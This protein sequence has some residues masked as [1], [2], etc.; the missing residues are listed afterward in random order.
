MNDKLFA[1]SS[2]DCS[3]TGLREDIVLH[4]EKLDFF[5]GKVYFLLGASGMG[6]STLL[7]TL[8]LMN[9]TI[10]GGDI[11][12]IDPKTSGTL[13]YSE[14]WKPENVG[15]LTKMRKENLSFIFQETNLMENFTAHENVSLSMMIKENVG[16]KAALKSALPLLSRVKLGEG[17][18][19]SGTLAANLSGGQRQR[20]AFVRALNVEAPVLLCDEPT[21]N[22]DEENANE[23]MHVIHDHVS[24]NRIAIIVSHDIDLAVKHADSII[25]LTRND[26]HGYG[27]ISDENIFEKSQWLGSDLNQLE[28]FKEKI[29]SLYRIQD[30]RNTLVNKA[31]ADSEMDTSGSVNYKQLFRSREGKA[32]AGKYSSNLFILTLIL[33]FTFLAIGFANGS[34]NYLEKQM[35]SVFVNWLNIPVSSNN[36]LDERASAENVRRELEN[37]TIKR[38]Y[39]FSNVSSYEERSL[40]LKVSGKDSIIMFKYRTVNPEIDKTLIQDNVLIDKNRL[41]GDATGITSKQNTSVIVTQD[42]L[43]TIHHQSID[44]FPFLEVSVKLFVP[45]AGDT[46]ANP[47]KTIDVMVKIPIIAVVKELPAGCKM[48]MSGELSRENWKSDFDCELNPDLYKT[49]IHFVYITKDTSQANFDRI[50]GKVKQAI[51]KLKSGTAP[52]IGFFNESDKTLHTQSLVSGFDFEADLYPAPASYPASE[53]VW[54]KLKKELGDDGA[55]MIRMTLSDHTLKE[56]TIKETQNEHYSLYFQGLDNLREFK[57]YFTGKTGIEIDM[58]RVTEKENFFFLSNVTYYI[59]VLLLLFSVVAVCLFL[60]NLIRMHLN[61]IKMNIGTYLA[62]GLNKQ[63]TV[64]IYLYIILKFILLSISVSLI[65]AFGIGWLLN[66]ILGRTLSGEIQYFDAKGIL[67]FISIFVLLISSIL[68][69]F[70]TVRKLLNKSPGDLIYNR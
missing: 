14:F 56:N 61:K 28:V 27:E 67:T 57:T 65:G 36:A 9:N 29:R 1:L 41:K 37:P 39:L 45:A 26:A 18:V 16:D 35:N 66:F 5:A 21:G 69:S 17:Y 60:F 2:L 25:V 32:L 10:I 23:L 52:E 4:I 8:G 70:F 22:L 19:Q 48:M 31:T 3:Y 43:N 51:E 7:E 50:H 55:S 68:V 49:M 24:K 20:L 62:M 63:E 15:S 40:P 33:F 59:S 54:E 42:L 12:F 11:T 34:L 53:L 6:K 46:S 30:N 58:D 47:E 13:V 64:R 44:E 38:K